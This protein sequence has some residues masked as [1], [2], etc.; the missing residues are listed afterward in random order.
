MKKIWKI[1]YTKK[2]ELSKEA[3]SNSY[4]WNFSM[5]VVR[6]GIEYRSGETALHG[7]CKVDDGLCPRASRRMSHL[8]EAGWPRID[9]KNQSTRWNYV[10]SWNRWMKATMKIPRFIT[11][12][13]INSV[14]LE[15]IVTMIISSIGSIK[16]KQRIFIYWKL[17]R[18]LESDKYL[19]FF[20]SWNK[21][22]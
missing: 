17:L 19:F 11:T 5:K 6:W 20:R 22:K 3:S 13:Y 21:A 8:L 10:L 9:K 15:I 14:L 7:W 12:P 18:E 1:I 16:Y 2:I 4:W